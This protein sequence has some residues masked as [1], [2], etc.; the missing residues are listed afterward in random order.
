[1]RASKHLGIRNPGYIPR[2]R[3]KY[4]TSL[5]TLIGLVCVLSIPGKLSGKTEVAMAASDPVIA[6][7][8]DIACDPASPNFNGGNGT[9]TACRQKYTS[10]LLVNANLAAVLNLGD[11]QY[12]CGSLQAFMQSYDLSWGRVKSITY[13]VVGNHEYQTTGGVDCTT[14]NAGATGY[15]DY[16]GSAAGTRGQGYYSYDIGAWH[17]VALNSN[18]AEVGGCDASS[19]QGQWL[20]ADLSTHTNMC[21]LAY[22]HHPLFSSGTHASSNSLPFWQLLYQ[23]NADLIL[24][25]HDHLYERFAPQ[26]PNGM[27]DPI[28]GIRQFTIGTG[29]GGLHAFSQVAR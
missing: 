16:F 15:F 25:G 18:C 12:E 2:Q 17:I 21:T 3:Y 4:F 24:N 9:T 20:Q 5:V 11:A 14:A 7:A 19:P 8:G 23:Y 1:M 6:A 10:D 22:F 26:S 27:A 13:P 29:G 28:N